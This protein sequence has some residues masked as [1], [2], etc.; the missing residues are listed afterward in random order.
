MTNSIHSSRHARLISLIQQHRTEAGLTQHEVAKALGR[1]QSY[2][3][4]IER[5]QRRLDVVEFLELAH[6]IG[7][8]PVALMAELAAPTKRKRHSKR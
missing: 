3:A 8:D 7:A 6:A 4:N 1:Y 5:G 2:V